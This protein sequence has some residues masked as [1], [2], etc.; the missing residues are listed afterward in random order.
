[1]NTKQ[2]LL[3]TVLVVAVGIGGLMLRSRQSESWT[4]GTAEG[5]KLLVQLPVGETLAQV[6][7]Q[8]GTNTATLVKQADVWRVQERAGHPANYSEISSAILKLRDLKPVETEP[9][10]AAQ[11][12]RLELLP[13]GEGSN[14]ATRVEF[15]DATGK[16]LESLSLGKT[17]MQEGGPAA[18]FEGGDMGGFPAGRWVMIGGQ[19]DKVS[20]V[21]DPLANLAPN[22]A[23]WLDKDFFKVEKIK[24]ITVTHAAAT[25]SWI[26]SRTNEASSDW[27]LADAKPD[28]TLDAS[29]TSGFSWALSS[30]AFEDVVVDAKPEALG[31]DKP[32]TI[33]IGTFD[34]LVYTLKVGAKTDDRLAMALTVA[35]NFPRDRSAGQDEK[36]EDKSKLDQ[37]FADNLKKLEVKLARE[38]S[39]EKWTYLVSGYTLD[40]VMKMRPELL[41]EKKT[42]PAST[43]AA[44][45]SEE[46]AEPAA[47]SK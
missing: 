10:S 47:N 11:L 33:T 46:A 9:I 39:F 5:Q 16:V 26:V 28:E 42:E 44:P 20:L 7:I 35:G 19:K 25:N 3:L 12:G 31:L 18:Q 21:S 1:M 32:T 23:A 37:A 36:P 34:G 17:Q 38:K 2:I 4:G 13:P 45:V 40:S 43:N 29:K 41:Q 22:P 8:H 30:P 6:V 27:T 15:R 14:T 24:S